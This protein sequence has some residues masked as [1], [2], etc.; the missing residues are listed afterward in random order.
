VEATRTTP[1]VRATKN[2]LVAA[3]FDGLPKGLGRQI[4]RT[5]PSYRDKTLK[6]SALAVIAITAQIT[7]ANQWLTDTTVSILSIQQRLANGRWMAVTG[8]RIYRDD[9]PIS[10]TDII[11]PPMTANGF[12]LHLSHGIS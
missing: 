9:F 8:R 10:G 12:S 11:V 6:P 7:D 4:E 1:A 2:S 5:F 3:G